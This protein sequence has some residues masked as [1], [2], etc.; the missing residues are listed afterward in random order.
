MNKV[1]Y[2][3]LWKTELVYK[4]INSE[5]NYSWGWPTPHKSKCDLSTLN[6]VSEIIT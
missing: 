3:F 2:A 4:L 5:K 1:K 6:E